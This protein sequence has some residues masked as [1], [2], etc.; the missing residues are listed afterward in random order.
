MYIYD[1]NHT[2]KVLFGNKN[3]NSYNSACVKYLNSVVQISFF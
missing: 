2:L 1:K 3:N